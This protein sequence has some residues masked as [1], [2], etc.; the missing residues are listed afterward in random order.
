MLVVFG[1]NGFLGSGLKRAL[2]ARGQDWKA[3][4]PSS[5]CDLAD[6]AAVGRFLDACGTEPLRIV[7]LAVVGKFAD[8]TVTGLKRNVAMTA[9]LIQALEGRDVAALVQVSSLDIYGTRPPVPITE[10]SPTAPVDWYGLAKLFSEQM[11]ERVPV[12]DR[13]LSTVCLPGVYGTAAED[14]S[15]LSGF[16]RKIRAGEP[17]TIRGSGT[18]LRD[19]V[20]LD[21]VCEVLLAL[22]GR[23]SG[24][25]RVNIGTGESL[26]IG[27]IVEAMGT[28]CARAPVLTHVAGDERHFDVVLDTSRLRRVLPHLRLGSVLDNIERFPRAQAPNMDT[29]CS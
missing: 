27:T 22:A 28:A 12:F 2:A 15:V 3:A 11:L 13:V 9:G 1:A 16:W 14:T 24:V 19:Y 21:D 18:A 20:C 26:S 5:D 29:R 7:N 17:V 4:P 25:G 6:A 10:A 23:D 8:N